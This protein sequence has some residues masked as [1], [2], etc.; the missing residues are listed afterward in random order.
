MRALLIT[1]FVIGLIYIFIPGP[2]NIEEFSPLPNSIKSAEPGDT[3]QVPNLAAYFSDHERA[4]I[5]EFYK[6]SFKNSF[7]FGK[8]IPP[9]SLNYPPRNAYTLIRDQLYATFL[10]EYTYPLKGSLYVAG[11]EPFVDNEM[12]KRPHN[13]VGDHLHIDDVYYK[14]KTTVRFYPVPWHVSLFTYV[15]IWLGGIALYK[16]FQRARK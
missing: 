11:Y 3:R 10:E 4:N 1:L 13:F 15:G 9:I 7:L 5:T 14:S 2:S 6:E 16:I 8:I 12:F